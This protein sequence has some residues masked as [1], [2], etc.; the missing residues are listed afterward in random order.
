MYADTVRIMITAATVMSTHWLRGGIATPHSYG[1]PLRYSTPSLLHNLGSTWNV[2]DG[3]ET[4]GGKGEGVGYADVDKDNKR[5]KVAGRGL[6]LRLKCIES[7]MKDF[8]SI[9]SIRT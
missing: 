5:K 1:R 7:S 4:T 9:V 3:L 8:Q 6:L 2:N